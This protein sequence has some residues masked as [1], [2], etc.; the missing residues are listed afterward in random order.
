MNVLLGVALAALIFVSAL[1][2]AVF[3][4]VI[5]VAP[6]GAASV[7]ESPNPQTPPQRA[8]AP[9][10]TNPATPP[11]PRPQLTKQE[12][13]GDWI[14]ACGKLPQ[15]DE[16]RCSI[17]QTLSEKNSK[18]LVF[19]WR[20]VQD[21]KGGLVGIWQ[22]P[23]SVRLYNGISLDLGAPEPMVIPFETCGRGR[24]QAVVNLSGDFI[25]TLVAAEKAVASIVAPN[26]K[27]IDLP[28]SVE[29]LSE[30]LAALQTPSPPAN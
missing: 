9:A 22:T 25:N 10:P 27:E 1:A 26:G 11:P 16:E 6:R 7:V 3:T 30:A 17:M 2:A 21:G 29:G 5:T 4:G 18:S 15:G 24:C 23:N 19:S 8:A 13:Y 14:Y 12:T 28:M 20:I